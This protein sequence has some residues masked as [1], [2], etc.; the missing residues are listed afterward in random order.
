MQSVRGERAMAGGRFLFHAKEDDV[1]G[2]WSQ[3]FAES[4]EIESIE[5]LLRIRR[6]E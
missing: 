4:L 6:F 1:S 3:F 5:A 2:I